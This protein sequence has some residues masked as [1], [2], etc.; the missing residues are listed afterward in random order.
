MSFTQLKAKLDSMSG[1]DTAPPTVVSKTTASN[2]TVTI[3]F[4]ESVTVTTSGWSFKKNGSAWA[5]SSVTG[6]G[7]TWTFTLGSAAAGGDVLLCS[8]DSTTGATLDTASNELVTFTD[9]SITNTLSTYDTDASAFF[10]AAGITDTTQKNAVNQL[11]LDL[12]AASL[13]TK[14]AAVYPFV[15]GT[16]STHKWNLKNPADTNGAYRIVWSGTVTHSANGFAGDGSTGYGNTFYNPSG[17]TAG[18]FSFGYYSRDAA[19]LTTG[20]PVEM[21]CKQ[22]PAY[23]ILQ[24]RTSD[25]NTGIIGDFT[26]GAVTATGNAGDRLQAVSM[27]ATN[28]R[29]RYRD[30]TSLASSTTSDT[31]T[32]PSLNMYIGAENNSGVAADA[33]STRTIAFAYISSG[34][35]GTEM[36]ALKTAVNAFETTLGR[37]V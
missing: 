17:I 31:T 21:G 3:V 12:K 20:S 29:V 24:S 4:S 7:T 32:P 11:V 19:S 15:G 23:A 33:F 34:L 2:T 9:S 25:S 37:N 6:S 8:Y 16:A 35:N 1:V 26:N 27:T 14:M 5:V 30:G 10:T 13:W 36:T 28:A 18:S 22:Y